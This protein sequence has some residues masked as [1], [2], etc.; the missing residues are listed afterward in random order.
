MQLPT[1]KKNIHLLIA[2]HAT[3]NDMLQRTLLTR[4]TRSLASLG[5]TR[6]FAKKKAAAKNTDTVKAPKELFGVHGRYATA[7]FMASTKAGSTAKV[8]KEL[9][10]SQ[11][12]ALHVLQRWANR[13]ACTEHVWV[14]P[15]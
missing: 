8:E 1:A 10:V 11:R 3:Y 5:Q 15:V 4:S 14:W 2:A 12:L 7:L 13:T 9:A 6:T